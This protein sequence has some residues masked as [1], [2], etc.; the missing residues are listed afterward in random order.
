MCPIDRSLVAATAKA[1]YLTGTAGAEQ[2]CAFSAPHRIES[3]SNRAC[4]Q[5]QGE[6]RL[7]RVLRTNLPAQAAIL[8]G[9]NDA[10]EGAAPVSRVH[11]HAPARQLGDGYKCARGGGR[12]GA[13]GARSFRH[14]ATGS[15]TSREQEGQKAFVLERGGCPDATSI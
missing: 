8:G 14:G 15:K 1:S 4:L 6:G 9:L 7:M 5:Q 2:L 10:S 12:S 13:R 3:E 11:D